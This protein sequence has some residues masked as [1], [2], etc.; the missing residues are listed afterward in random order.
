MKQSGSVTCYTWQYSIHLGLQWDKWMYNNAHI[1]KY[2]FVHWLP[3]S[4]Q[5]GIA[6]AN[7]ELA[8]KLLLTGISWFVISSWRSSPSS[9]RIFLSIITFWRAVISSTAASSPISTI[10]AKS[11]PT[12]DTT[13]A[14]GW[15]LRIDITRNKCW[16]YSVSLDHWLEFRTASGLIDTVFLYPS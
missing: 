8:R 3:T 1:C 2:N 11:T 9:P 12:K 15:G 4:L 5:P 16:W 10:I 14:F 13:Q 7:I 6:L